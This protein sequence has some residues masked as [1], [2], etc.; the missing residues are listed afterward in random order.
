MKKL[1]IFPFAGLRRF[2]ILLSKDLG[3]IDARSIF[4]FSCDLA[5]QESL[6]IFCL[7][8]ISQSYLQQAPWKW[9]WGT[10]YSTSWTEAQPNCNL[11]LRMSQDPH[12]Q[13][14]EQP[15]MCFVLRI[16]STST[17]SDCLWYSSQFD[18]HSD[19]QSSKSFVAAAQEKQGTS[20]GDA[21]LEFSP[22]CKV[23]RWCLRL[24]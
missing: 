9:G 21:M 10:P 3:E 18:A 1:C 19:S 12:L 6:S 11:G 17:T 14:P 8:Q 20:L 2:W 4:F 13:Q 5:S 15:K 24:E 22:I 23:K 7:M 16:T